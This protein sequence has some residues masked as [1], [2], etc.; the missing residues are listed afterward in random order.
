MEQ[1]ISPAL[2]YSAPS[3]LAIVSCY[4]NPAGYRTREDN[5]VTFH[6]SMECSGIPLY[7]AELTL[8]GCAPRF[9][10][11]SGVIPF[12]GK[13]SNVAWQKERLLNLVIPK[14]PRHVTK[15]AWIDADV[16]FTN[17]RWATETA[18][19]L[20][21]YAVV[22]PFER[23]IRL[24]RGHHDYSGEGEVCDSFG[25]RCMTNPESALSD[26]YDGHGHTGLAWAARRDLLEKHGLFDIMLS[27]SGDH[28]IAHGVIGAFNSRCIHKLE[29]TALLDPFMAWALPFSDDAGRRIAYTKGFAL[30]LWH[31]TEV[32]R[33]Y[34]TILNELIELKFDPAR[35]IALDDGG[36]WSLRN[37]SPE[38][39]HW[40]LSYFVER[41]EDD[42]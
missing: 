32:R 18:D 12:E 33:R 17:P 31:G 15:V 1:R 42:D 34:R 3:D 27:G 38:L 11:W 25:Y 4:F 9:A 7:V 26:T 13:E 29:G 36:L 23:M 2:R 41:R 28:F 24:P 10:S 20:D 37:A 8:P 5:F 22:Q 35:D 39:R 16:L 40:A 14:L 21:D 30:H 6:R 19:L